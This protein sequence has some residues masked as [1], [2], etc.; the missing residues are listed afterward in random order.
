[1][2][3][4]LYARRDL[5]KMDFFFSVSILRLPKNDGLLFNLYK[6]LLLPERRQRLELYLDTNLMQAK[7][8]TICDKFISSASEAIF[9][10]ITFIGMS[11]REVVQET[12]W[13]VTTMSV[14]T[15]PISAEPSVNS[16]DETCIIYY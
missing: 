6:I 4:L 1:M 16:H 11:K 5:K 2:G 14:L 13:P 10:H 9:S 3:L 8:I 15:N 12:L 7:R